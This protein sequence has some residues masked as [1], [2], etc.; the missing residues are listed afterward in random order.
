MTER[1]CPASR[2][3]PLSS[4]RFSESAMPEILLPVRVNCERG[5]PLKE[6]LE[7]SVFSIPDWTAETE[8]KS[9]SEKSDKSI[10]IFL[11][12]DREKDTYLPAEFSMRVSLIREEEKTAPVS[13][14][15]V[16][17]TRRSEQ[18]ERSA[19]EKSQ[20]SKTVSDMAA[21]ERS[22]EENETERKTDERMTD[23]LRFCP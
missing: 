23:P 10:L 22:A 21:S 12:D 8:E 11:S 15:D 13:R 2:R 4:L 7:S 3:A 16:I 19:F 5:V 17:L 9:E 14:D 6:A 1:A 20:E 18:E